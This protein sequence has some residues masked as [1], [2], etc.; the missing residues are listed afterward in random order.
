MTIRELI[1]GQRASL[2]RN[3]IGGKKKKN[4]NQMQFS[5]QISH[6]KCQKKKNQIGLAEFIG[7]VLI[8]FIMA[9]WPTGRN[10]HQYENKMSEH[11]M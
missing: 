11:Q 6:P 5:I 10:L 8:P 4:L 1:V 3:S 9:L 7:D 2:L